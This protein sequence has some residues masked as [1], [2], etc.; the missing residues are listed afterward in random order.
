MISSTT[1]T[2]TS[3]GDFPSQEELTT[4]RHCTRAD[5]QDTR[6]PSTFL[7]CHCQSPYCRSSSFHRHVCFGWQGNNKKLWL[8]LLLLWL[9]VDIT[10]PPFN[11]TLH[12]LFGWGPM[13]RTVWAWKFALGRRRSNANTVAST[14]GGAGGGGGG[15]H[16]TA[17]NKSNHKDRSGGGGVGSD[18]RT[19]NT[20]QMGPMPTA[21][22]GA[23]AAV[24]AAALDDATSSPL[25][26]P[27]PWHKLLYDQSWMM[28]TYKPP[29][30]IVTLFT[31]TH[32][33]VTGRLFQLYPSK[34]SGTSN[35]NNGQQQRLSIEAVLQ[36]QQKQDRFNA[37]NK[38]RAYVLDVDDVNYQLLGGID[39]IRQ[40]LICAALLPYYKQQQEHKQQQQ[41]PQQQQQQEQQ[42]QK[43]Q[44]K[45][46]RL[47][48][49]KSLALSEAVTKA[50]LM[51]VQ[52]QQLLEQV[53]PALS[54]ACKPGYCRNY[55]EQMIPSI[56]VIEA[57]LQQCKDQRHLLFH[58]TGHSHLKNDDH[59]DTNIHDNKVDDDEDVL[60]I[61]EIGVESV[62][63]KIMDAL[64]R[65][66]RNRLL[67]STH[68]L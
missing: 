58:R 43:Q 64:V 13:T 31:L 18:T 49:S 22:T 17:N 14:D 11:G 38:G 29:V 66:C 19:T 62:Q 50:E 60:R 10:S 23:A 42:Q 52:Q 15:S 56:S 7:R 48:F 30:G 28:I 35:N 45:G 41:Q 12:L 55:I 67:R 4:T 20:K 63:M 59:H 61:L 44:H 33:V 3:R 16:T 40:K 32:L 2:T 65:E 34:T 37:K 54:I 57:I 1:T 26:P 51:T 46:W 21:A 47:H 39:S 53:V 36:K 24:A 9:V 68:R 5:D 25:P 27:P 8:V 6:K